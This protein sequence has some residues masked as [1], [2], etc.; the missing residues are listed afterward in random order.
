MESI[1]VAVIGIPGAWSSEILK[2]SFEEQ[3]TDLIKVEVDIFK[4]GDMVFDVNA[5]KV[6][7][8]GKNLESYSAVVIKKLGEYSPKII[9]WLD[10]L[11][12]IE[13][14]GVPFFSSPHKLKKMISRI[15]CTRL[16]AENQV[17]MPPTLLTE[18]CYEA[19]AWI[20]E[21]A[22]A[23]FKPNFSTKARGMEV[24]RKGDVT[25]DK[26]D[27]LKDQYGLLYLQELVDLPGEDYGVVFLADEYVGT[28]ARVGSKDSWNT[29][30]QDGGHYEGFEPSEEILALAKKAQKVFDLDFC[31]VDIAKTNLGPIVFEV[32]AFGGFKGMYKGVGINS[33]EMLSQ[34][35]MR[36]INK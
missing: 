6:F 28:Y 18:N 36:K 7:V 31:C 29:T 16:L 13:A 2:T 12:N 32:S 3:S 5:N 1:E 10:V 11:C 24:L 30:T 34:Y 9:D 4:V 25:I 27:H 21:R 17:K 33:A 23:V 19:L 15:G 26:L 35:V 22:G 14:K 20:E 8:N